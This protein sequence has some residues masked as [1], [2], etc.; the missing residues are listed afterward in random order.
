MIAI[1]FPAL[2]DDYDLRKLVSGLTYLGIE[3]IKYESIYQIPESYESYIVVGDKRCLELWKKNAQ[4]KDFFIG[5]FP[6]ELASFYKRD[7]QITNVVTIL[8]EEK[9]GYFIKPFEKGIFKPQ[10]FDPL[11]FLHLYDTVPVWCQEYKNIAHEWRCFVLNRKVIDVRQ[12]RGDWKKQPPIKLIEDIE[13]VDIGH[14]SYC[15]DVGETSNGEQLLIEVNRGMCFGS[16]GLNPREYAE[17]HCMYW[18]ELW[19]KNKLKV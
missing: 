7:I 2:S 10:L 18:K 13:S 3:I 14:S 17:I 16:Y 5:D 19:D 15:F 8:K 9:N 1:T 12:Y 4:K 6:N 11:M